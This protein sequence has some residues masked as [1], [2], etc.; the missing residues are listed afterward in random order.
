V[1]KETTSVTKTP[2]KGLEGVALQERFSSRKYTNMTI[3]KIFI[4]YDEYSI[5]LDKMF[6]NTKEKTSVTN[7]AIPSGKKRKQLRKNRKK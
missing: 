3:H 5:H 2:V 7:R 6:P 1:E 4:G